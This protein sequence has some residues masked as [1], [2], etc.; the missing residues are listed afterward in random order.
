MIRYR[1]RRHYAAP[2][3]VVI[4]PPGEAHTGGPS[5]GADFVYRVMYPAAELLADP[6]A[7]P[8]RFP[9]PVVTDP[10]L[11]AGLRRVHAALSRAAQGSDP[12][13]PG[14]RPAGLA[15]TEPLRAVHGHHRR[16]VRAHP[17][18]LCAGHRPAAPPSRA[19]RTSRPS[20]TSRPS[21]PVRPDR[22]PG[23]LSRSAETT[24]SIS[25]CQAPAAV[26]A[27]WSASSSCGAVGNRP[28]ASDIYSG[29]LAPGA[30]PAP[31]PASMST[32]LRV[33]RSRVAAPG[34]SAIRRSP[35]VVS[36]TTRLLLRDRI[37]SAW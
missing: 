24:R 11:A 31:A 13:P 9:A 3:S 5:D 20:P 1:G 15:G 4:L 21:R 25:R 16:R 29:C 8:P 23:W 17:H 27:S 12:L 33:A 30:E 36:L 7:R 26:A 35:G 32:S 18:R 14:S 19:G 37:P 34:A 6:T 10:A 22:P 2:G 28:R